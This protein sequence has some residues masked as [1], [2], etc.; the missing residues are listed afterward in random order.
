MVILHDIN[1]VD[2]LIDRVFMYNPEAKRRG[3]LLKGKI[4]KCGVPYF[5]SQEEAQVNGQEEPKGY[6]LELWGTD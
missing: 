4:Y 6:I 5:R 3:H 1:T 2:G